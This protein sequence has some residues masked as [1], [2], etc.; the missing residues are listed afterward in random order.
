MRGKRYKCVLFVCFDMFFPLYTAHPHHHT[1]H[2]HH[3]TRIGGGYPWLLGIVDSTVIV[4][5]MWSFFNIISGMIGLGYGS[6]PPVTWPEAL[7]CGVYVWCGVW[8]DGCVM[9]VGGGDMSGGGRG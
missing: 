3:H 4:Q 5:Y 7:V 9:W 8:C 6:F 1:T 2:P